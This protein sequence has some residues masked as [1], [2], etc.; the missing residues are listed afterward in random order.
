LPPKKKAVSEA[1]DAQ[2]NIT[3]NKKR[4]ESPVIGL[5][6]RELKKNK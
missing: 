1:C 3:N 6:Q 2:N 5:N 4:K